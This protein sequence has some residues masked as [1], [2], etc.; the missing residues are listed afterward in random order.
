M[1]IISSTI[2]KIVRKGNDYTVRQ[3]AILICL[4]EKQMTVREAALVMNVGK[5]VI[6]RGITRLALDALVEKI[7]DPEDRRSVFLSLTQKGINY[8]DWVMEPPQPTA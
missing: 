5:P 7:D 2:L 4:R 6:S 1:G 8:V 3:M